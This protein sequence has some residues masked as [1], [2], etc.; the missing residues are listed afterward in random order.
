MVGQKTWNGVALLARG[1]EPIE[2]RRELPGDPTD[3]QARFIEAAVNGVAIAGLYLPNGNPQPGPKFEYKLAWFERLIEHAASLISSGNPCVIAGDFNVVPT[4]ELDIYSPASWKKNALLQPEARQAYERLLAQGW[5]DAL[6]AK[7][8]DKKVFTFWDFFRQ[9]FERDAGLRIDHVLLTPNSSSSTR[10]STARCEPTLSQA[11]T[12]RSWVEFEVAKPTAAEPARQ[13]HC[14]KRRKAREAQS[15]TADSRWPSTTPSA[16]SR[17]RR[18]PS[19][20]RCHAE[21]RRRPRS[22]VR[23]PEALGLAAS[24]RLSARAR[25]RDEELGRA[26]G[27]ELRPVR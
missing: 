11:T 23:H 21:A 18:S 10:A 1:F 13:A 27:P 2:I 15:A 8:P 5:T 7:Y 19:G 25:W 14:A 24:L 22:R 17:R 9:H 26:Q 3:K 20:R 4:D 12:R 6:R 16:T